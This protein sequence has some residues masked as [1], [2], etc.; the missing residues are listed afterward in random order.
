MKKTLPSQVV[1]A[2]RLAQA[3]EIHKRRQ[4]QNAREKMEW[5]RRFVTQENEARKRE[6]EERLKQLSV[7]DGYCGVQKYDSTTLLSL[8]LKDSHTLS[9]LV[10]TEIEWLQ[11]MFMA[12]PLYSSLVFTFVKFVHS[13][14]VFAFCSAL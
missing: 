12:K 2:K 1:E 13:F 7:S 5:E 6:H 4:A 10:P 9:L 11:C 14:T 3:E 8:V